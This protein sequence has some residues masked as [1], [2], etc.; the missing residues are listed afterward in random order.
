MFKYLIYLFNCKLICK[1]L[2]NYILIQ[3]YQVGISCLM[4]RLIYIYCYKVVAF[5]NYTTKQQG[6]PVQRLTLAIIYGVGV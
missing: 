5:N 2:Y 6:H 3:M 4:R 1:I